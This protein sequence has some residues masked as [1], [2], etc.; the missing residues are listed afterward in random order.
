MAEKDKVPFTN[1]ITAWRIQGLASDAVQFS[2]PVVSDSSWPHGLQHARPPC[3][4]P[5][6]GDYSNSS[7][8]GQWCHPAISSSVTLFSSCLQS[9]RHPS[10][11]RVFSNESVLHIGGQ[12]IGASALASVLPVN[13]QDWFPLVLTGL[14]SLLSKRLLRVFSSTTVWKCKFFGTQPSLW[15]NSHI[16]TQ[17]L[18]KKKTKNITLTKWNLVDNVPV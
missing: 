3:P 11:F 10:I 16:C 13:I 18:K 2:C 5:T 6:P 7:P 17:L 12:S 14:I 8:S 4:S 1:E 15:F 9:F